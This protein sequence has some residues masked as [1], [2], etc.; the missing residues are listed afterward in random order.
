MK[1]YFK[2]IR[3]NEM[4]ILSSHFI[5]GKYSTKRMNCSECDGQTGSG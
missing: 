1:W 3:L 5:R 4:Y 2:L